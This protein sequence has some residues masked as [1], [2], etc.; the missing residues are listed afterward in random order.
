MPNNEV[1]ATPSFIFRNT[2]HIRS[3]TYVCI[4]GNGC[5]SHTALSCYLR[6]F[7]DALTPKLNICTM[8]SL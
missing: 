1:A 4:I 3:S 7:N 2:S 8:K 6:G 5:K